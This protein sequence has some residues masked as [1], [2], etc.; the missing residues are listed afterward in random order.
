MVL[1]TNTMLIG[2]LIFILLHLDHGERIIDKYLDSLSN[3][4]FV[5][6]EEGVEPLLTVI[7]RNSNYKSRLAHKVFQRLDQG[8]LNVLLNSTSIF[9]ITIN[10]NILYDL[11]DTAHSYKI[12]KDQN[13]SMYFLQELILNFNLTPK[14]HEKLAVK[15][16]KM[17]PD[18]LYARVMHMHHG[19]ED[20]LV[21]G[22]H[23]IIESVISS[24]IGLEDYCGIATR[25]TGSNLTYF[26]RD[27]RGSR[28]ESRIHAIETMLNLI[29][30]LHRIGGVKF[31][32][33]LKLPDNY[34]SKNAFDMISSREKLKYIYDR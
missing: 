21:K 11:L 22:K 20:Y 9:K 28:H 17:N 24:Y 10:K 26:W 1:G 25:P 33:F 16:I 32:N 18:S 19:M 4:M 8:S 30:M 13:R 29:R 5:V 23:N 6:P 12:L 34:S 14:D 27:Y 31:Q 3:D 2:R 15:I 7:L